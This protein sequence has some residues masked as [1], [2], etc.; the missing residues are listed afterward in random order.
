VGVEKKK[1]VVQRVKL[2]ACVERGIAARHTLPGFWDTPSHANKH[3]AKLVLA[4]R[5]AFRD[6]EK[7]KAAH[8]HTHKNAGWAR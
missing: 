1:G 7:K 4:A 3:I 8:T 6:Q 5:Q 2:T